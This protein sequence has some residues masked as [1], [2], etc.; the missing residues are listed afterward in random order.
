M[1][2]VKSLTALLNAFVK[3]DG[4]YLIVEDI[5]A[6]A[7]VTVKLSMDK[8]DVIVGQDGLANSARLKSQN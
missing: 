5:A 2:L 6:V 8:P 4:L 7:M 1:V 3:L